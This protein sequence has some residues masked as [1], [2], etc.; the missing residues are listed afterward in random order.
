MHMTNT[1]NLYLLYQDPLLLK[2]IIFLVILILVKL[3]YQSRVKLT[4]SF[5]ILG[6][7]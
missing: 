5:F 2:K 4:R 3:A 7:K 6:G 1:L